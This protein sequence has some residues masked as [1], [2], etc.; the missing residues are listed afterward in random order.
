MAHNATR[1]DVRQTSEG[2]R[3]Q[4]GVVRGDFLEIEDAGLFV[5]FFGWL[6]H[7]AILSRSQI[8]ASDFNPGV[9]MN[10]PATATERPYA[11]SSARQPMS[12]RKNPPGQSICLTTA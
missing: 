3:V 2:R 7:G 12:V 6:V 9:I 10:R 1:L 5:Q 4:F 11:R 8:D